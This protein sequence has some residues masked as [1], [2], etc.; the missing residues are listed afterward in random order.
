MCPHTSLADDFIR[1]AKPVKCVSQ[2]NAMALFT[3]LCLHKY[4]KGCNDT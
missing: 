1:Y 2:Q 3:A 4:Y